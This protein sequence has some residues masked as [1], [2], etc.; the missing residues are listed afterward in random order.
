MLTFVA[1]LKRV[2]KTPEEVLGGKIVY[3]DSLV[4]KECFD[5]FAPGAVSVSSS[6]FQPRR[7]GERVPKFTLVLG[8]SGSGKTIFAL[9]RLPQLVFGEDSKSYFRVHF[10]AVHALRR[11]MSSD[12]I[13]FPLAVASI[14]QETV[15]Q[16]LRDGGAGDVT[17]VQLYLHVVID[18]AGRED[19][20]E[21]V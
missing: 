1:A 5:M 7:N 17:P 19:L 8:S 18:E 15:A 4:P 11:S 21:Y 9:Q 13:S 10:R 14:V 20:K 6:E 2:R 16:Q 3:D 12:G